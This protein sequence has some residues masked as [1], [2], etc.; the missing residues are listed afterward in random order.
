MRKLLTPE[1]ASALGK[2]T[3]LAR[4][5]VEGFITGLHASPFHGFS[6]EFSEHRNYAPGDDLRD[7][8]WT[9]YARTD[10]Y[11]V[12]RYKEETNLRCRLLVDASAS[13]D[14]A[15]GDAKSKT[16]RPD[17]LPKGERAKQKTRKDQEEA[18]ITKLAYA[19]RLAAC[20]AYL[21]IRQRDAVG[22]TICRGEATEDLAPS[23]REA[24]LAE[25]FRRL[26]AVLSG[27]TPDLP[28]TFHE[29][30]EV[31]RRRGLVV[32]LSDLLDAEEAMQKALR[33]LRH[34]RHEVILFHLLDPAEEDLP[35]RRIGE[36]VDL[37][38]GAR[39]RVDPPAI[40][41]EYRQAVRDFRQR[42]RRFAS[43]SGIDYMAVT[44]AEPIQ[45]LLVRYL[46]RRAK[47]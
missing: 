4:N 9:A 7:L 45:E 17:P 5:V 33:H 27:G 21:M 47:T 36:F 11:V 41:A 19:C 42:W 6:V 22:L 2:L 30:A 44:T 39:L 34:R 13:M 12:K 10:R 46:V 43:D 15:S 31:L 26:E 37:E 24:H 23:A 35:Y 28:R 18:P 14:F 29:T 40:R 16:P 20:L 8:D 1:S 38:N 25:I 3:L 32:V